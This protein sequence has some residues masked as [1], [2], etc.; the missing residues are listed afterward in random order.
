MLAGTVHAA[1]N[2]EVSPIRVDLT[3]DA[4]V[5]T[6]RVL[7]LGS[8]PVI[9]HQSLVSWTQV[10]GENVYVPTD[11]VISSPPIFTLPG[12]ESQVVRI[13]LVA[14]TDSS[15]EQAYRAFLQ[16]VPSQPTDDGQT[17]Q[18]ALRIGIPV[19]VAPATAATPALDWALEDR[20]SDGLWLTVVNK[21]NVHV[22][23]NDVRIEGNAG[24]AHDAT[25]HRYALPGSTISWRIDGE[26]PL[27]APPPDEVVLVVTTDQG[28]F[29]ATLSVA[30]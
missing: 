19:F 25:T 24:F 4:P 6:V 18:I 13:G 28:V 9:I 8:E 29:Q 22:L 26:Y 23:V 21:G 15:V 14:T 3:A 1:S 10:D 20:G 11:S 7:N 2:F 5:A 27:T 12:G 30:R 16:E 17:V